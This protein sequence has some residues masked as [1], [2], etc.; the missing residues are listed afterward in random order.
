MNVICAPKGIIDLKH[1]RQGISDIEKA[2]FQSMSLD[3]AMACLSGELENIGK[4]REKSGRINRA[5]Q[6]S[7]H[8]EK[9]CDSIKP[10]LEQCAAKQLQCRIVTA[11]YLSWNA[12]REDLNALL[13]QLAQESIKLCGQAGSQYLIVKPLTVGIADTDL[14]EINQA[15]YLRQGKQAEKYH[16]Q[17]LLENQCKDFNGHL[18]RG[19]CADGRQAAQW[20]DALN[21]AAGEERFGFCM[22]AGVCNLCGQNMY[23]FILELGGRLK[24]VILRDNDG[25]SDS[26]LLPFTAVRRGQPQTDWL[27]LIRGLREIG[28]DGELIMDFHDTA[29]AFSPLLRPGLLQM[30]KSVAEYFKWQIEIENVLKKYPS[31]VLFGAGNMCR[32]YMK[33]YGEKYPPL[34]TCD[35]NQKLWETEFCGLTVKPPEALAALPE[36]CAVFICNI[37]YREIEEQLRRMGLKNPIAFFND[38]Y[39][40]SFY[41]DRVEREENAK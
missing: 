26:A 7:A 4:P 1:P 29:A 6:L 37:Y 17:I 21:E 15:Y 38:E 8:P 32:N 24:A 34:F 27:N 30:A 41:F 20:V 22:D 11:P 16:V 35:N 5:E 23:D 25:N 2:G 13:E 36:D 10:V 12:K 40:P 9:L 31:R 18:I 19:L 3:L 14:W 33:C 28:F 39:M